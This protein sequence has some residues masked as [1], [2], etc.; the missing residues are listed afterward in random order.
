MLFERSSSDS[1]ATCQG[2]G[3][4]AVH[5]PQGAGPDADAS[6]EGMGRDLQHP[7]VLVPHA[8]PLDEP[9]H[10]RQ[11]HRHGVLVLVARRELAH[12][13]PSHVL[14]LQ[15]LRHLDLRRRH[16]VPRRVHL[17]CMDAHVA[18]EHWMTRWL[19]TLNMLSGAFESTRA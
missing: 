12:H 4:G 3:T 6:V 2:G 16:A 13:Q 10:R 11:R 5:K 14:A 17:Q 9:S 7:N 15:A 8:V 1:E 19:C 18:R